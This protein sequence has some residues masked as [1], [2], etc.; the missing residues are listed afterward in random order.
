MADYVTF[1]RDGR[2]EEFLYLYTQVYSCRTQVW[3]SKQGTFEVNGDVITFHLSA[4]KYQVADNCSE[5]NNYTRPMTTE[6]VANG[7]EQWTWRLGQSE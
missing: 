4:G 1:G 2:Y 3:T 5:R 6:E 7:S